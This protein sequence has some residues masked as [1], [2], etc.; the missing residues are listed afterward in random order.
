MVID[1]IVYALREVILGGKHNI[2]FYFLASLS[3]YIIVAK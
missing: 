1:W 3:G 2:L